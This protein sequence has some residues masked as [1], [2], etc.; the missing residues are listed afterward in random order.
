MKPAAPESTPPMTKPIAGSD[1]LDQ[2]DQD[3][4]R[5]RDD[6]DDQVLAVEVGLGALLDGA[7]DLLHALVA[8]REASRRL[9]M[10]AP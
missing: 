10:R 5:H 4:Q 1:V 2:G 9:V 8:G 3:R 7:G 6:R